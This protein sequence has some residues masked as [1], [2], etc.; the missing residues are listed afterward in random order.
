M[1]KII[2]QVDGGALRNPGPAAAGIVFL[3]EKGEKFKEI[4]EYLGENLTNNQAEYLAAI[5]AL[6]K[7]K[8]LFGKKLAKNT[9]IEIRSDSELLVNQINGKY[10]ILDQELQPLF[11]ELWNLRF[12]FKKVNFR[13]IKREKNQLADK[14]VKKAL[15][16]QKK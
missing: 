3:N 11:L 5:C 1:K 8:T 2:I 13:L 14:L 4:S 16:E 9:E 6:K 7:F 12:D 10:K 15:T